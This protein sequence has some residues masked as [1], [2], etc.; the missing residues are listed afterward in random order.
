MLP[1][2]PDSYCIVLALATPICVPDALPLV[3]VAVSNKPKVLYAVVSPLT[4]PMSGVLYRF[5][6]LLVIFVTSYVF[7]IYYLVDL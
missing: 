1:A 5:V 2:V 4:A 6:I 3:A 7:V